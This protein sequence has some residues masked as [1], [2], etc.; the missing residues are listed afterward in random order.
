MA[1]RL[2]RLTCLEASCL[3]ICATALIAEPQPADVLVTRQLAARA[4]L[5]IGDVV[6]LATDAEGTRAA[7]FRVAGIYEPTPD[8]M[9]FT[10]ERM[11]ARMHLPDVIALTADP[12][13]PAAAESVDAINVRLVNPAEAPRFRADLR[14]IA[15]TDAA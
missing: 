3:L 4:H 6:T 11:E 7:R 2:L 10:A 12:H 1:P 14:T 9:R 8:P 13:D 5:A 15:N